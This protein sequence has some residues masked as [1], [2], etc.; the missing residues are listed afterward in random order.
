MWCHFQIY[1]SS[2][3]FTQLQTYSW[4]SPKH[5]K[6]NMP[7]ADLLIFSLKHAPPATFYLNWWKFLPS[8]RSKALELSSAPPFLHTIVHSV[9]ESRWLHLPKLLSICHLTLS[10]HIPV[11]TPLTSSGQQILL[12]SYSSRRSPNLSICLLQSLLTKRWSERQV[13]WIMSHLC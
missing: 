7:K 1:T 5:L 11:S 8:K 6:P 12:P 13:R 10:S 4:Y 2:P 9:S 3:I